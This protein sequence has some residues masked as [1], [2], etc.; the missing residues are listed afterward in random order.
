MAVVA[1]NFTHFNLTCKKGDV[2]PDDHELVTI[3]PHLFADPG[4]ETA[5]A[6]TNPSKPRTPKK[7]GPS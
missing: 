2:L 7:G 4:D 1:H 3:A 5:A 6:D